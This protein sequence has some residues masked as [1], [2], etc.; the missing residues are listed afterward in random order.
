MGH[1]RLTALKLVRDTCPPVSCVNRHSRETKFDT[2][3]LL[4]ALEEP[5]WQCIDHRV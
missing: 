3:E 1:I 4:C 2:G 5:K